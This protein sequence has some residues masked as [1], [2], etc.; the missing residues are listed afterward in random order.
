MLELPDDYGKTGDR[1]RPFK[2]GGITETI[3]QYYI[4]LYRYLLKTIYTF[5]I[6]LKYTLLSHDTL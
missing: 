2:P 5:I 6:Y 4:S 3:H 1:G